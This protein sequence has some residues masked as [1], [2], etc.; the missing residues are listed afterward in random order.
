MKRIIKGKEY[1]T[2]VSKMIG[3]HVEFG[4]CLKCYM[5]QTLYLTK[6]GNYFLYGEGCPLVGNSVFLGHVLFGAQSIENLLPTGQCP[7]GK[8]IAPI[9]DT[10]AKEWAKKYL[11]DEE[12]AAGFATTP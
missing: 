12:F 8:G 11:S 1:D 3:K 6:T 10:D 2:R 7:T 9:S 4:N 5:L